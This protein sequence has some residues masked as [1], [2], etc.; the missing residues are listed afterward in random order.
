MRLLIL[1][2]LRK[3]GKFLVVSIYI[4]VKPIKQWSSTNS[5]TVGTSFV[6]AIPQITEN[7]TEFNALLEYEMKYVIIQRY[8]NIFQCYLNINILI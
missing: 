1:H 5:L 6:I 8:F 3:N 2:Y 4:N 7:M